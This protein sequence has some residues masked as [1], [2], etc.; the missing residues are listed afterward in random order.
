MSLWLKMVNDFNND[1]P[2][3]KIAQRYTNPITKKPYTR[4]HVYWVLKKFNTP[5]KG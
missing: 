4:E 3:K 1:I 2:A 5:K